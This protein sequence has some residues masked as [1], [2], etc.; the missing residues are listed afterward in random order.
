MAD[1]FKGISSS[2]KYEIVKKLGEGGQGTVAL[3]ENKKNGKRYAAKWYNS[4]TINN[5]QQQRL[6]KLV[7]RGCPVAPDKG[8][9][10]IW[11]IEMIG[12]DRSKNG[13]GYIMPL[14]DTERFFTVNKISRGTKQPNLQILSRISYLLALSLDT[15]HVSGLAYCDINK[16]NWMLDPD[17]GDIVICDNDNVVVNNSNVPVKGVWEFMA[18]EVALGTSHPNAET[19]KYSIA[20][21]LYYL[22]MW[23]HPMEGKKALSIYSW[24]IPAKKEFYALKPVFVFDPQNDSNNAEGVSDLE[25][26][27]KRWDRMCPPRLK[28]MFTTVFTKG[29]QDPNY[30]V[31]LLDWQRV[32]L[33]LNANAI[34]CPS[35]NSMNVWDGRQTP[36]TCFNCRAG[37]PFQLHLSVNHGF[38]EETNILVAPGVKIR[39]H[40]LDT[41]KFG[42]FAEDIV[43][44]IEPHPKSA[45]ACIL[46]NKTGKPWKYKTEDGTEY[47]IEPDQARALLSN[48]ELVIDGV[49]VQVRE[50]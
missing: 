38:G 47:T 40:H 5:E 45:K 31:Q 2:Q 46:R 10:F 32:F 14:I 23:E 34:V 26:S 25:T 50:G 3:V 19:D 13:F 11:P 24:D 27:V 29:V 43:G 36:L 35:C 42:S 17:T 41:V 6:E 18:P 30:R 9:K 48:S 33:E 15:I 8:I 12:Y 28:E 44:S 1:Y 37:I 4:S 49:K 7:S 39:R 22:W 20:V 21:M 16:D